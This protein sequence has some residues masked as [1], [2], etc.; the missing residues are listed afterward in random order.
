MTINKYLGTACRYY[1]MMG[2]TFQHVYQ[3]LFRITADGDDRITADGI[4]RITANSDY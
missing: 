2:K 1:E 3:N 4:T